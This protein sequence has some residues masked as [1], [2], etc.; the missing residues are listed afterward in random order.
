MKKLR[1]ISLILAVIMTAALFAGCSSEPKEKVFTVDDKLS[2][3][4]DDSFTDETGKDETK[5]LTA[6]Y[7]SKL[8]GVTILRETFETLQSLGYEG[9]A[10]SENDYL[11]LVMKA[12]NITGDIVEENGLQTFTTEATSNDVTFSYYGFV[13]KGDDSFW[14]IQMYSEKENFE[15]A[16]PVFTAWAKTVTLK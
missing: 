2:I 12:N 9:S 5:G 3:T 14:V 8:Y 7:A 6:A 4:L 1:I 16:K 13:L 10:L 15:A 11:T